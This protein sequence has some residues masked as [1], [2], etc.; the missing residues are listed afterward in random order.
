MN[1]E[2]NDHQPIY[3]QLR[4]RVIAM[5]LDGVLQEGD[6]LPSVRNVAAEEHVPLLELEAATRALVTQL[7]PA[8]SKALYMNFAPGEY[9]GLPAGK[10]DNTHFTA[11]GARLVAALAAGEMRRLHLP[12]ADFSVP[13]ETFEQQWQAQGPEIRALLRGGADVLVHCKGGLGRAGMIAARLLVELGMPPD[14]AIAAVRR[15]RPGAIETP[16][17][18][19]LVRRTVAQPDDE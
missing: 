18:L 6:P 9:P 19:G 3:R 2:W 11:T 14:D 5:I 4:D 12:I 1:L 10:N 17:Q 7:G 15:A 13:T 8:G 16:A